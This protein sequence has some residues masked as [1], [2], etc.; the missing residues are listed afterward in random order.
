M[1]VRAVLF[2][3]DG[4]L[5][6]TLHDIADS[7]NRALSKNGFPQHPADA[8]RYFVGDGVKTLAQR[9]TGFKEESI[10]AVL[11]AYQ[12][13]YKAGCKNKTRPYDG[14]MELLEKLSQRGLPICIFSNKP[15]QDTL[16]VTAYYFKH[17]RFAAISGQ[18]ENIPVKPDPTGAL[19]IAEDLHIPPQDFLYV[20]DTGVDMACANAAGMVPVGALWGFRPREE[21]AAHHARHLIE[22]P[23]ELLALLR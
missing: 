10:P 2:D 14:V 17:I 1:S 23:E 12:S 13:Y 20:G 11:A 7:M 8:Y 21:L 22:K 19:H 4:T 15:H 6:N 5:L 16:S 9:A 3:L 18:K